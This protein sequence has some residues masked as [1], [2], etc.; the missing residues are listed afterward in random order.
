[1]FMGMCN[2]YPW[3]DEWKSLFYWFLLTARQWMEAPQG[4]SGIPPGLE[5]MSSLD[6]LIVKQRVELMES[7]EWLLYFTIACVVVARRLRGWT[8]VLSKCHVGSMWKAVIRACNSLYIT[9]FSI[10]IVTLLFYFCFC[11]I[12]QFLS[13]V[14]HWPLFFLSK[15]LLLFNVKYHNDLT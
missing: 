1:M 4:L 3:S 10:N 6:Q 13:Q 7:K 15:C 5:Y 14:I 9:Q 2:M 12:Y 8:L 11:E